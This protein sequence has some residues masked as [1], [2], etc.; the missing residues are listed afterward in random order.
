MYMYVVQH[1]SLLILPILYQFVVH[2]FFDHD[3]SLPS[4]FIPKRNLTSMFTKI[5]SFF[6]CHYN[7]YIGKLDYLKLQYLACLGYAKLS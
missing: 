2:A 5:I 7:G 6:N 1:H 4:I 3:N